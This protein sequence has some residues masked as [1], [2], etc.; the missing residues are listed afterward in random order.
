[1][2][3]IVCNKVLN[4]LFSIWTVAKPDT[5]SIE[6]ALRLAK[7]KHGWNQSDFAKRLAAATGKEIRPQDI[8]NWKRRGMPPE[9]IEP[10]SHVLICSA[11]ELLGR[12][13]TGIKG[14]NVV[15]LNPQWPF[16]VP[17][18][19]YDHLPDIKKGEVIA[20]MKTVVREAQLEANANRKK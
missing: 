2:S 14:S 20:A 13:V 8:T 16:P 12:A 6:I 5:R 18:E 19:I 15:Q 3:N 11:D 7:N 9:H 17:R 4:E 10:A 1:M